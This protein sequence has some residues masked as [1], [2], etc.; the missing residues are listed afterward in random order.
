MRGRLILVGV[1]AFALGA[2]GGSSGSPSPSSSAGASA[3][4]SAGASASSPQSSSSAAQTSNPSAS[5]PEAGGTSTAICD[6]ISLRKQPAATAAK[7]KAINSGT[8]V[9]VVA[10]VEGAAYTAGACGTSG[11]TWLQIDTVGGKSVKATYGVNV[12]YA[13]AGF[14]Q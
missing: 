5:L 1:L 2:C 14:F 3:S 6:G 4:T 11:S 13:A 8:A 7:V 10:T 9:H 12:V